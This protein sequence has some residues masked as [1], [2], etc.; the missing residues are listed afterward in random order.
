MTLKINERPTAQTIELP[1]YSTEKVEY[2]AE[3]KA[4]AY[5]L[6]HK[7]SGAR[8]MYI[9][10]EDDNKVFSVSFRTP[11]KDSTGVAHILEHSVL[12]GSR[13]FP[14]KEPFVELVKGSLNTFLNAMTFPD[15]TMYPV[16]SKN[17]KDFRNLMDVYLDAVFYPRV[18]TDP[19]IVMQEGWHY[20]LDS[21]EQDVTYKGV[22]YNEMKGVYSS[23]D[24][25]L[26][27]Y[28]MAALFPDTTYG[29]DSGGDPDYITDLTFEQF[30][31]FYKTYYHPG[32][33]YTFL[34]GTMN[35][36]DQLRFIDEEYLQSF[37]FAK[38]D[39]E[40]ALQQPPTASIHKEVAFPLSDGEQEEGKSLHAITYVLPEVDTEVGLA[41]EVLT[42]A[43]VNSPAGPLREALVQA[44][45]GSDISA[46]YTDSIRQPL[47]NLTVSGTNREQGPLFFELVEKILADFCKKG[48]D[49]NLLRASLN[50][51]EFSLREA[52][53]GGRPIGLAYDIRVMDSWLYDR[54]PVEGLRYE[55]ALL[56]LRNGLEGNYFETLVQKYLLDNVHKACITAYP[57]KGLGT[58]KDEQQKERLT[59]YK[60][61][62]SAADIQSL[63]EQT[64]SLK[65]RQETPDTEEALQTIPLL[66]L[67]DL[68][69]DVEE[70]ERKQSL[71][72]KATMHYVPT[73]A[74]GIGYSKFYF[75]VSCFT[76][77]DIPYVYLLADV[78]GRMNT[79]NY[80][81]G[82]IAN[83]INLYLGGLTA[84]V[85]AISIENDQSMAYRA[86]FSV[87]SKA[88]RQNIPHILRLMDELLTRTDY[89][90]IKRLGELLKEFKTG[91]DVDAFRKGH[92]LVSTR[93][94][95]Q[96]SDKFKFDDYGQLG[97][98]GFLA[99]LIKQDDLT[100]V[101]E[102]LKT[103]SSMLFKPS[104]A[105]VL[106]V[107]EEA[108][109]ATFQKHTEEM[110]E[111][112]DDTPVTT[113]QL[114]F[115]T[116]YVN[117]GIAT[118]GQVQYVAKGGNFAAHGFAYT[119]AMKVLETI[120]KYE[121]LWTRIRVQGG[122]YGAF[123]NFYK[124]GE[125]LFCSYRDPNL[126]N[127]L[128][129]YDEMADYIDSFHITEREMRKYIIGTMSGLD[130][131]MTPA[132]RGAQAMGLYF[133]G[134]TGSD[135]E[136]AKREVVSVKE[137]DIRKLAEVVRGVMNDN[138]I[139]AMGNDGKIRD[140]KDVFAEIVTLPN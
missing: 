32:N 54:D 12:C 137:A 98:Y 13:K 121:Y 34:Y 97:Y 18:I 107:G 134:L 36:E 3:L 47:W 104:D 90:D 130:L 82:E 46:D 10:A 26:E 123:A 109:F 19:Q 127:T 15:K 118:S 8:I 57:E 49:K 41:F 14:L 7:K 92:T 1:A 68:S 100:D 96:I 72:G 94:M 124:S 108:D 80:T 56:A 119:G 27:R 23:S 42:H 59:A 128:T 43:L 52:D 39:S 21:A 28:M 33:S 81:Y 79:E 89:S 112:W 103:I 55:T 122:A 117:E 95:A 66:E 120:L 29:V 2:I 51:I 139:C 16:A 64:A 35:I 136:Q 138:H 70:I 126:Q 25:I 102:K 131:P 50:A 140:A 61:S 67:K 111:N 38:A 48:F 114:H 40:I 22:V 83:E 30:V 76:Q 58:K 20:E 129:V 11:P 6:Q 4:Y 85:G 87:S 73:F 115:T 110:L 93:L 5:L 69:T 65:K 86:L 24:A 113:G 106:F 63:V 77:E 37:S 75:D 9:D 91:W 99:D 101:A 62:L 45:V 17:D 44:G 53:F 116:S 74:N 133:K 135:L 125:M 105:E 132:L 78:F 88:L 71:V 84:S 60:A 31:E